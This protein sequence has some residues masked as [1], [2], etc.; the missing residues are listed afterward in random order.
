MQKNQA[1]AGAAGRVA[2]GARFAA[3]RLV[4]LFHPL[5]L[6]DRHELHRRELP[7]APE[8]S[9][10]VSNGPPGSRVVREKHEIVCCRRPPPY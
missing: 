8:E 3:V 9:D 4:L 1:R 7:R 6:L 5:L 2:R 10:A